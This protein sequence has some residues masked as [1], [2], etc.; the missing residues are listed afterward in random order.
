M[1]ASDPE[2]TAR[3]G[4]EGRRRLEA[5]AE[6]RGVTLSRCVR[7]LVDEAAPDSPASAPAPD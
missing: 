4:P 3:F 6:A 1:P 2:L 7:Q 5:L